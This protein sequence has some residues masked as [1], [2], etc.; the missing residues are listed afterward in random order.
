MDAKSLILLLVHASLIL[1]VFAVGLRGRWSEVLCVLRRPSE[2][3]RGILA[4]NVLVPAAAITLCLL[5]P[6]ARATEAGIILM[7]VSPMAPFAPGKMFKS[8]S[9]S[10]YVV[11]M[12]FALVL[13]AVVIV[14]LTTMLL[15]AIVARDVSIS[16]REVA[17]LVVTSVLLPLLAGVTAATIWPKVSQRIVRMVTIV[18]Y[19]GLL[20]FVVLFLAKSGGAIIALIGDGSLFIIVITILVGLV[21]GHLLGGPQPQHRIALA[22]AAV[23]RHPGIAGLIVRKH[24]DNPKIMLAVILFLLVGL[25]VSG[26]YQSWALKRVANATGT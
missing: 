23:T 13:V 2:L 20:P 1:I 14:P 3:F 6:T 8:G 4:V 15:S 12:Y 24:F 16:A 25:L 17:W 5:M 19:I 18:A 11:G 9:D 21:A 22:E 10:A 26:F 7:A